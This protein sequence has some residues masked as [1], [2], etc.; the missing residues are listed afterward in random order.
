MATI[1]EIRAQYPQYSDMPDAALADGMYKKFYAD[2]PRADFDLK[3]GFKPAAQTGIP[4][5]R[6]TSDQI[7]TEPGAN[8]APTS[9]VP[10]S[11]FERAMGNLE[12]IPALAGG[13]VGG[14]VAPIAGVIGALNS[15]KYGTPE[16]VQAGE[17]V[18]RQVQNQ[19]YQPKTPEAQRNV[20]VVGNALAPLIG[21]PIPTLNALGQSAPAAIRAVRD[22]EHFKSNLI[23]NAIAAPLEARAARIQEG[24]VAGSYANAPIID[25]TQAAQRQG[26][27]VDPAVTNPTMQNR[28]KGMFVGTSF[29]EAAVKYNA[30]RATDVVRKD[31]GV[32]ANKPLDITA[33]ETAL[34][35][36]SKPYVRIKEMPI[37]QASDDV[38]SSIKAL[39]KPATLGGKSQA[40][41]V[42]TLINDSIEELQVGRSG[43][44]ILD[45]IRQSRRQ[46]QSVYKSRDSGGNPTP[47]DVAQ[48]D[49]RMGIANALE[50]LIDDNAPNA[51]TLNEFRQARERM[52]QIYDHERTI[53]FS[54][55]SVDPQIYAKLLDEK[56]GNMTG[57]GADIGKVAAMF[58]NL[59]STQIPAA[60]KIPQVKRSGVLGAIGALVGGAIAGYPGAI[61][62]ASVGATSG[63]FGSRLAA[64]GM[65]NPE[66]QSARAVPPDYRP[67]NML[68]SVEPNVV[69]NGLVPYDY[70]QSTFTPP[71]FVI[72]P[73]RYGQRATFVG[74]D[75]NAPLQ[76]GQGGTMESLVA[77]RT[78][79]A[80]MSRTLGQQAEAQQAA[81]EALTRRSATGAVEM[82]INPLTG[83]PEI[84][85]GLKGATPATFQ[86]FGASL[87]SAAEKTSAGRLF[88]LTAAEKV[89][90][91]KTRIDLADI[92]P[93]MKALSDKAIANK[94]MDR[95]WVQDAI[96]KAKQKAE[97]QTDI[98]ARSTN[99]RQRQIAIIERDKLQGSL[100]MLEEQFRQTRPDTS[101]KQ[102]GK[103]T[104]EFN[105]NALT[106]DNQNKLAP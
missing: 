73:E 63:Y 14:A 51:K 106:P 86:D 82:Q 17:N 28:A 25:A 4:G 40:K 90:F 88:D 100:E 39:D 95:V 76:I 8:L 84:S 13:L 78:R 68:R 65:T 6:R 58:P 89:A 19:F 97:M 2:M 11:L 16:G 21:V 7:P 24:R 27:A 79:A 10:R 80:N 9:Y 46:A 22:L 72:V 23:G 38:L 45:D 42:T 48:A 60:S 41:A 91:E 3:I 49:A 94:F 56:K 62:G 12:T 81:A 15:G 5:P 32:P 36:A 59:M 66:Y 85:K 92:V 101:S 29:D 105:R 37:L 64:R 54:N 1:S 103:K 74:P 44:Q 20:E 34:D 69:T 33:I 87:K 50:K 104:R 83:A 67:S 26:F 96:N 30:A 57:V 98:V 61:G 99:E 35:S 18:A 53:N 71:N 43:A 52:A 55:Q 75:V 70:S 47:A 93:G 77:E 102:Q 31:L